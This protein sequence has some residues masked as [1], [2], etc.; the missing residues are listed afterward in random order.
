MDRRSFL[1]AVAVAVA[2]VAGA[3]WGALGRQGW[4]VGAIIGQCV[5]TGELRRAWAGDVIVG[6]WDG[7]RIVR[8]GPVSVLVG[9]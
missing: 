6:V 3:L 4:P 5:R 7:R 9:E 2:P 8:R 1:K